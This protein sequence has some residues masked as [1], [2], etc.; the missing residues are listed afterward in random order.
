MP[1]GFKDTLEV[2]HNTSAYIPLAVLQSHGMPRC[3]GSW[4]MQ[5][6]FFSWEAIAHV[7]MEGSIG[8]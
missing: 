4:E 6:F 7:K 8:K 2:G 1:P 5:Y 3:K